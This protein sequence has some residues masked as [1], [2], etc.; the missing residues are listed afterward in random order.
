LRERSRASSQPAAHHSFAQHAHC[1]IQPNHSQ[2]EQEVLATQV[3]PLQTAAVARASTRQKLRKA[4][5]PGL[6]FKSQG[7]ILVSPAQALY[8]LGGERPWANNA[9]LPD[10]DIDE[11]G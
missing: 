7:V 2:V 11:L 9:H 1:E 4:C 3:K 8:V 5:Y 10:A 6:G